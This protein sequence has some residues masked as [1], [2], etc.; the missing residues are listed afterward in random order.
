MLKTALSSLGNC[1]Q[2]FFILY[3]KIVDKN[4]VYW[5]IMVY[6]FVKELGMWRGIKGG[7]IL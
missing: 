5:Y 6:I 2:W 3:P 7:T 1:I 4:G